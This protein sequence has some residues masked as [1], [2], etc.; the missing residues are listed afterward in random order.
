MQNRLRPTAE[1]ADRAIVVGDPGRSLLLAQ[2]LLEQPKMSNHARGLW[3]YT[4]RRP[5]GASLTIQATGIGGPSAAVVVDELVR[6]HGVTSLVR[7][8]S[9]LASADDVAVGDLVLVGEA[10]AA[11]GSGAA[12]GVSPGERAAPDPKLTT[13]LGE[14]IGGAGGALVASVDFPLAR[15][16]AP[17]AP[18]VAVDMQTVAVLARAA[19]LGARA[20]AVLV[21]VDSIEGEPIDDDRRDEMAK[22]A[23]HA[24]A[25]A[26]EAG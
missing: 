23:G 10:L 19:A 21:A 17:R 15:G 9:C 2:E 26:L 24:A 11:G 22:K 4:G 5:G 16:E 1:I 25:T 12:L 3:G 13:L 18:V 8:G 6:E 20:A 7:V 14:A